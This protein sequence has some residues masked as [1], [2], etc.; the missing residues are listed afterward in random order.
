MSPTDGVVKGTTKIVDHGPDNIRWNLVILSEG[1]RDADLGQF[2]SAAQNFVNALFAARPFDEL[3]GVINVHRVDV[4]SNDTGADDPAACGGSGSTVATYFDASFC[5]SGLRRLLEVNKGTL[6]AVAN[7]QVPNWHM[8]VVL[9][10]ST[11]FGGSGG[12]GVAVAS[13]ADTSFSA[14]I[15]EMGHQFGLADEYQYWQRCGVDTDRTY[16]PSEEPTEPNVTRESNRYYIKWRDLIK[17]S[18]A[19]PT[20]SNPNCSNCDDRPS[21]VSDGTVGAF[22][23]ANYYHCGAYRPEYDCRMKSNTAPFCTVCQQ[24]IHSRL[25]RFILPGEVSGTLGLRYRPGYGAGTLELVTPMAAGGL[26]QYWRDNSAPGRPWHGPFVFATDVGQ[27]D[28]VALVT[29]PY[30]LEVVA[31]FGGQLLYYWRED[32]PDFTWHG[33]F[34]IGGDLIVSGKPYLTTGIYN[35]GSLLT[36]EFVVPVKSGGIAHFWR[37][38]RKPTRTWS[39]P[40]IFG[41]DYGTFD[42]VSLIQSTF[43]DPEGG[44]MPTNLEVVARSGEQLYHFWRSAEPDFQW[45]GPFPIGKSGVSGNPSL[46]QGPWGIPYHPKNFELVVPLA[47]GGIAYYWRDNGADGFPWNGPFIFGVNVGH[48]EALD[49]IIDTYTRWP[50]PPHTMQVVVRFLGQLLFYYRDPGP[51]FRWVL[52]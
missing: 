42:A 36:R 46:V 25:A 50:T 49:M 48:F 22:E 14:V 30:T 2:A 12:A 29:D 6:L 32:A 35:I 18:T 11:I 23:G 8:A 13:V 5:N 26:G 3:Q 4:S 19:V 52:L 41:T 27:F 15:H 43:G 16:H 7:A 28:D 20:M 34:L 24:Q 37:D 38:A 17:P 40:T 44:N 21:P 33:P 1:Y 39:G 47:S 31:R 51:E 10:N 45:H 9:V